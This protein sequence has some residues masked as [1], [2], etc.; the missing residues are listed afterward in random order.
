MTGG[1]DT[2]PSGFEVPIKLRHKRLS[3]PL[4]KFLLINSGYL[5]TGMRYK[6]FLVAQA[7][8]CLMAHTYSPSCFC[9]ECVKLERELTAQAKKDKK[10]GK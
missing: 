8:K 3:M 2:E 10:E 9:N 5:L 4:W 1:F 6:M 7:E